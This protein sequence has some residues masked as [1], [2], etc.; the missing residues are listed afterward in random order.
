M[1]KNSDPKDSQREGPLKGWLMPTIW[2]FV[3]LFVVGG[4]LDYL[5]TAPD[6]IVDRFAAGAL[7][8]GVAMATIY[9]FRWA[10]GKLKTTYQDSGP[11][12]REHTRN[13][14]ER[15]AAVAQRAKDAT[16][17]IVKGS[18][19]V[20]STGEKYDNLLKLKRLLDEGIVTQEEYEAEKRKLLDL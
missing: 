8:G 11:K 4:L 15:S 17:N 19:K 5:S 1:S 16:A 14:A 7:V 9:A 10:W 2:A 6:A 12:V 3:I 20:P 18:A 13:V